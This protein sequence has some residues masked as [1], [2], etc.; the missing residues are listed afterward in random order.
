MIIIG[1][2]YMIKKDN[3]R[4]LL[5]KYKMGVFVV[6][7]VI[8]MIIGLSYAWLQITLSGTKKL[9]F[10]SGSLELNLDDSMEGGITV[11]NAVPVTDEEGLSSS[12]YTF[13][14]ENT[15]KLDSSYEIYLDDL[16][17][18]DG[19]T[20]MNDQFI[21]YQL[22]KDD[23]V[24]GFDLLSTTGEHPKR[25]FDK[26]EIASREKYTYTLKMWIDSAATNE[27]MNT[28]FRGNLRVEAMQSSGRK[29]KVSK[30]LFK[31]SNLGSRGAIDTSDEEQTFITGEEPNNYIWYSGKLWR[32]VSKDTSDNSVKLITQWNMTS[33]PYNTSDNIVFEGSY[34]EEW[35]N[36]TSVDGFLGN[37]REPEKFIKMDSSW[38]A[39]ETNGNSR[40]QNTTLVDDAVGLLNLYEYN[41]SYSGT[42]YAL[43]Y[44]NNGLNWIT[45]TKFG[46]N[47]LYEIGVH[48]RNT[49]GYPYIFSGI[50]PVINLKSDV[51]IVS[52]NGSENNPY[53]LKGDDVSS[54]LLNKRYSGEYVR[55]GSGENNLYRIVSH[56][57]GGTKLISAEPLKSDSSFITKKFN[58]N[59][60]MALY[61]PDD[62]SYEL[63]YFLNHDFLDP[64]YGYITETQV[65]MI[66]EGMWYLGNLDSGQSYKLAKYTDFSSNT[67]VENQVKAKVGLLRVGEQFSSLEERWANKGESSDNGKTA[68][69]WLLTYQVI[70]NGDYT[71]CIKN[72]HVQGYDSYY[73]YA[74]RPSVHLKST[75]KITGGDGTK[76]NPFVISEG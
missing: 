22:T 71:F 52:G 46:Q 23:E 45:L 18:T 24:I 43:G 6:I 32:A 51:E 35:L 39:T 76:N 19:Q 20:R 70:Q 68:S 65:S 27:V 66:E 47:W 3:T 72:G 28:V 50:R 12:A 42:T 61:N 69:Y 73:Q 4:G 5:K 55:F 38:N 64:T 25:L 13:T 40:P 30:V 1:E 60:A 49:N 7:S 41:K 15:G 34:A 62:T 57:H 58:I 16:E 53:R 11:T 75:I 74:I 9:T 8:I 10:S 29:G 26:G 37:L 21:K 2:S 59:N 14:L 44:L 36:D 31:E 67:L 63:A 48:G 56:E 17:L 54:T 33:I